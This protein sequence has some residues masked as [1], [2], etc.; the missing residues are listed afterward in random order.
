MSWPSAMRNRTPIGACKCSAF[1]RCDGGLGCVSGVRAGVG[2]AGAPRQLTRRE[3]RTDFS[4]LMASTDE[5]I[6]QLRRLVAT[7][8]VDLDG[9]PDGVQRL[10]DWFVADVQLRRRS[11]VLSADDDVPPW[12]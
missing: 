5:R 11:Q 2:S 3:A 9:W 12:W 6:E 1:G 7:D 4:A 8:G 10:N